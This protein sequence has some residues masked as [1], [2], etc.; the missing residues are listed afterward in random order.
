M[1]YILNIVILLSVYSCSTSR[2]VNGKE[3]RICDEVTLVHTSDVTVGNAYIDE[4]L[5]V[6]GRTDSVDSNENLLLKIHPELNSM[7]KLKIE[8]QIRATTPPHCYTG[9]VKEKN[10]KLYLLVKSAEIDYNAG[11]SGD[12]SY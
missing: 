2:F 1:K 5:D 11:D 7:K 9:V 10:E 12:G 3:I 4:D 6:F 8:S